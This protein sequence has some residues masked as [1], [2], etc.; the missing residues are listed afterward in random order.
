MCWLFLNKT[1]TLHYIYVS[2]ERFINNN[3]L[4]IL[5]IKMKKY[6]QKPKIVISEK[7]KEKLDNLGKKTDTYEDIIWRLIKNAKRG[8]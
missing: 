3:I 6:T 4:N 2:L 8:L 1:Y 5:S 7:L